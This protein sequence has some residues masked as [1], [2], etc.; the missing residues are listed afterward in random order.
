[1]Q[2]FQ[3]IRDQFTSDPESGDAPELPRLAAACVKSVFVAPG[4]DML[5]AF[6][7]RSE[8]QV[9]LEVVMWLLQCSAISQTE[10]NWLRRRLC[11]T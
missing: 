9:V 11:I 8:T 1:V 5:V 6:M 4:T 2:I 3:S 10:A 7:S